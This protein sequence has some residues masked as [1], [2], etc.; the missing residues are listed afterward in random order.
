MILSIDA[1]I[2]V[3]VDRDELDDFIDQE[4]GEIDLTLVADALTAHLGR[5]NSY[6][7]RVNGASAR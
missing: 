7:L 6:Y 3:K 1:S 4:T 2:E 5:R